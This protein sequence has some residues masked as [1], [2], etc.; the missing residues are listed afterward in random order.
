MQQLRD[1]EHGSHRRAVFVSAFRGDHL[2]V[3]GGHVKE[4]VEVR[5]YHHLSGT[6][7]PLFRFCRLDIDHVQALLP[8]YG[9]VHAHDARHLLTVCAQRS[10]RPVFTHVNGDVF[11]GQIAHL[12]HLRGK[13]HRRSAY[14]VIDVYLAAVHAAVTGDH[15]LSAHP[16]QIFVSN[17][18]RKNA[19]SCLLACGSEGKLFNALHVRAAGKDDGAHRR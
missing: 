1:I 2:P 3:R 7:L 5:R 19:L 16:F 18:G 17:V 10:H 6:A 14:A 8:L 15:L 4:I 9:R 12:V 13:R 11:L